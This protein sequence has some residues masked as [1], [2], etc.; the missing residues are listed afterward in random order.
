MESTRTRQSPQ[1]CTSRRLSARTGFLREL[2]RGG[3]GSVWLAERIDGKLKR[4]VALKIPYAGPYQRELAA[5]LARERD[6]L[7]GLEHPNI[8]RL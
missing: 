8:A 7:A 5:R 3:M 2:G 1:T 4:Q 6:I